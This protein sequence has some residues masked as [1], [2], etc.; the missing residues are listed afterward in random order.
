MAYTMTV[1][2]TS[3]RECSIE[4]D[5]D[6]T[7]TFDAECMNIETL[8]QL[9][10]LKSTELM[11]LQRTHEDYVKSSCEYE[12][13]LETEL[14]Q[15]EKKTQ[16]LELM[17]LQHERDKSVLNTDVNEYKDELQST[18]RRELLL[19]MQLED[20]KWKIQRLEQANDELETSARV[21]R[22]TIEDLHHKTE[23]LQ[24]Q[25][26]FLAHENEELL[27]QLSSI[28]VAEV[29]PASIEAFEIASLRNSRKSSS[30]HSDSI[31]EEISLKT[32]QRRGRRPEVLETC[33][34]LTCRKCRA[35]L[36]HAHNGGSD[37]K[38]SVSNFFERLRNFLFCHE[39]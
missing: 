24:E 29:H 22:A 4:L 21:A 3:N 10:A 6:S 9:L 26:V 33:L 18:H 8:A 38:G 32:K 27:K 23:T 15:F 11:Q 36:P 17:K 34:H 16:Q 28:M 37:K 39:R 5:N 19:K 30:H 20:M 35:N 31:Q 12:R 2:P 13:E 14:E 7:K 1:L 25:T